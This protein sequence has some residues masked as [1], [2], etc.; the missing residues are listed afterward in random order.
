MKNSCFPPRALQSG[1]GIEKKPRNAINGVF[2]KLCV[3]TETF[4]SNPSIT[5]VENTDAHKT[6]NF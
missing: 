6:T 1:E 2:G 5:V 4:R 3:F